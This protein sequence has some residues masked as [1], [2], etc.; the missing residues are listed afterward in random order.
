M[1]ED[2]RK[3]LNNS[4]KEIQA[5]TGKRVKA[6]KEEIQTSFQELQKNTNR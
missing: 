3:D 4:L 6:L 2:F 1:I 5:N